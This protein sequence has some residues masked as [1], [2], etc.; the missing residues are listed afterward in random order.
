MAVGAVNGDSKADIA[1]SAYAEDVGSNVRQG[2]AYVFSGADGSLLFTLD[3]LNP[4]A[5]ANFGRSVA[6]GEVNGDGRADI[7]LG[8]YGEDVGGNADQGRAYVFSP[9]PAPV[10]G[11]AQL[12]AAVDSSSRNYGALAA[13]AAVSLAAIA[14]GGWCARRRRLG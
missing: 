4:Q 11:I 9:P 2:R 10:G 12:P 1:V 6:M 7:A 13:L 8:A 14:A 5:H 3:T